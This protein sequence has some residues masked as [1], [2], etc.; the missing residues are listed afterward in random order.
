MATARLLRQYLTDYE[1]T[2]EQANAATEA[3]NAAYSTAYDAYSGQSDAYN[4]QIQA[5]NAEMAGLDPRDVFQ[6]ETGKL[7]TLTTNGEIKDYVPTT[8]NVLGMP[9]AAKPYKGEDGS[10][11]YIGRTP[12]PA[13]YGPEGNEVTPEGY[14]T[15]PIQI[16]VEA[17]HPGV[18]ALPTEPAA[19]TAPDKPKDPNL[20]VNDWE[21][22]A[23]PGRT[24]AQLAMAANKGLVAKS[25]L[26]DN[27]APST[28]SAF[29]NLSGDNPN[30]IKEKGV[31]ARTLAG[32]L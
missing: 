10:W 13:T 18:S 22:L 1:K 2:V 27:T 29:S 23:N 9:V 11:Y 28:N 8:S 21:E 14:T 15:G 7:K 30:N 16:A 6:D 17:V 4:A 31:L 25:E 12:V 20:T 24:P 26:A 19:P 32:Q 3:A 5:Y